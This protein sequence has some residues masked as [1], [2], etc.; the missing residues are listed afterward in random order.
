MRILVENLFYFEFLKQ[1]GEENES[2]RDNE[3]Q[4]N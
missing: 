1:G 2:S 3:T 4:G